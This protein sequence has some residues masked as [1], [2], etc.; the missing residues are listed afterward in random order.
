MK[1]GLNPEG[2]VAENGSS[3]TEESRPGGMPPV[4]KREDDGGPTI[5]IKV[6]HG[7]NHHDLT[8]PSL[9][10]FGNNSYQFPRYSLS[11]LSSIYLGFFRIVTKERKSLLIVMRVFIFSLLI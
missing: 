6:C 2:E 7:S 3:N 11:F 10:T 9:S 1:K 8:V 4:Q 5:K